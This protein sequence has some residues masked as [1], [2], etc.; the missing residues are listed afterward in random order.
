MFARLKA[1]ID[2]THWHVNRVT[3]VEEQA[4]IDLNN[5][6]GSAVKMLTTHLIYYTCVW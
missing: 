4:R 1:K 6:M 3:V 2:D 5:A